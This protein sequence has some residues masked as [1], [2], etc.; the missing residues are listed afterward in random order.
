LNEVVVRNLPLPEKGQ[1]SHWDASLPGFGIRVSQGGSKSW[2][3]L[4]PR[5]KSRTQETIGRY[6][7]I[8]LQEARGEAKRR[9]A[10]NTL[11]RHK[12]RPIAY[13]TAV[14]LYLKEK[15]GE[16]KPGVY[17]DYERVLSYFKFGKVADIKSHELKF[18]HPESFAILRAFFNWC[19]SK[20][21]V[22]ESPMARMKAPAL[23]KKRSRVLSD[24]ELKKIWDACE[25]RYGRLVK[26][27]M[28]TGQRRDEIN[29]L[30]DNMVGEH[31]MLPGWLT[32]N[33]RE[34]LVPIGAMARELL[35][36]PIKWAGFSKAKARLDKRS[37]V[38]GWRLHDLRRTVRTNLGKLGVRPDI[39]ERVVNHVSS[40]SDLEETYDRYSY[41]PE[42]RAALAKWE[43]YVAAI[44][45]QN[46]KGRPFPV[47]PPV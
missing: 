27:L 30:S 19:H 6:P 39:A 7:V 46:E 31:I 33:G 10:E 35:I 25:G 41:L 44:V 15:R 17:A 18:S 26:L 32:K 16:L 4:D 13:K 40:R 8:S 1:R 2:I 5:S 42:M 34:H 20:S 28:L 38:S 47:A 37:G 3:V 45:V 21:Y 43:A 14:E 11:G 29:Q 24:E 9:L 23:Y 22:S 36:L 12:P